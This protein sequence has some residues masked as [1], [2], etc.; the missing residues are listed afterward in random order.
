MMNRKPIL[1]AVLGA[2]LLVVSAPASAGIYTDQLSKCLVD[3]TNS[4][5]KTLLMKWVFSAFGKNAALRDLTAVTEAEK[6]GY[7][8]GVA[9]L[10]ERLLF[11]SCRKAALDAIRNEGPS[12]FETSFQLL[13]QVAAREMMRDPATGESLMRFLSHMDVA[14]FAAFSL[15]A[16][17][18]GAGTGN[19]PKK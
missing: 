16:G 13:G 3:S 14:K 11:N 19:A 15:E 12:A 2:G 1:A 6:V 8:K 9:T 4:D 18:T 10:F 7:D 17:F 5:D